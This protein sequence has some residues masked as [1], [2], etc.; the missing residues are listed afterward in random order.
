MIS[1]LIF[2]NGVVWGI[3]LA[4]YAGKNETV[5]LL[6]ILGVALSVWGLVLKLERNWWHGTRHRL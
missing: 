4:M 2:L 3:I 5:F 1:S 6:A